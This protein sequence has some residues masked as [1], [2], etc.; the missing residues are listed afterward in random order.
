MRAFLNMTA[1]DDTSQ[2]AVITAM[3]SAARE[4]AE[5]R[6]EKYLVAC[7]F[8]LRTDLFHDW[9][10]SI[11]NGVASIDLFQYTDSL[12][13][14]HVMSANAD[15]IVDLFKRPGIIMPPYDGAWPSF[16]PWPSSAILVRFTTDGVVSASVKE[17]I[18]RLVSGWYINRL[19][20]EPKATELR[21]LPNDVSVLL[22]C[23]SLRRF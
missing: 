5:R 1:S 13:S 21:E 6:Q 2:D 12:G 7:Q 10:I 23:G 20:Y 22:S 11:G 8:D 14:V 15:Y 19:P 3:I 16:T 4:E 17:G 18:K 9:K